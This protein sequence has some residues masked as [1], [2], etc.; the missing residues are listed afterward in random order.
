MGKFISKIMMKLLIRQ[1]K[2]KPPVLEYHSTLA[3]VLRGIYLKILRTSREFPSG[4][5]VKVP[6]LLPLWLGLLL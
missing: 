1:N 2:H 4:L 6:V 3:S 5:V